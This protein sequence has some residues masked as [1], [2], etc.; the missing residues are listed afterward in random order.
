MGR[1]ASN[2]DVVAYSLTEIFCVMAGPTPE[3]AG[4][5]PGEQ[6]TNGAEAHCLLDAKKYSFEGSDF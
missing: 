6:S 4:S 5:T 3:A 2:S 1:V